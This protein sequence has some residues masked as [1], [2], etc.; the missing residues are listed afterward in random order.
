MAFLVVDDPCC[1]PYSNAVQQLEQEKGMS[2]LRILYDKNNIEAAIQKLK[3][4][5]YRYIFLLP[6]AYEP[7]MK[8]AF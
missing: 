1:A 2:I 3:D 7:V 6:T 4:S 8:V 5:Q